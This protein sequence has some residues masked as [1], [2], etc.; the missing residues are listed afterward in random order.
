[1]FTSHPWNSLTTQKSIGLMT[2]Y[3]VSAFCCEML[4]LQRGW[5]MADGSTILGLISV[6]TISY[7]CIVSTLHGWLVPNFTPPL[8]ISAK[9]NWH[10]NLIK[11]QLILQHTNLFF[12]SF[13]II[14]DFMRNSV[15]RELKNWRGGLTCQ[16]GQKKLIG[17]LTCPFVII[18]QHS[19]AKHSLIER[20]T[21]NDAQVLQRN[22]GCCVEG[23][24]HIAA[25]FFNR[26][27]KKKNEK[28]LLLTGVGNVQSKNNRA[29]TEPMWISC[30]Y[31]H[32]W[33]EKMVIHNNC[34]ITKSFEMHVKYCIINVLALL[35]I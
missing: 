6:L 8:R 14:L 15:H 20:M 1:M 21:S 12:H 32:L 30:I 4:D 18:G 29:V 25:H 35:E 11:W 26:L 33:M 17:A 2:F 34:G 3:A 5:L 13:I 31:I 22:P 9:E 24:Q 16:V 23:D 19:E 7:H 28:P 27:W 10:V